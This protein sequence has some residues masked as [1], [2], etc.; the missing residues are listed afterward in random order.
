[1]S[2]AFGPNLNANGPH[3][4]DIVNIGRGLHENRA[5][6]RSCTQSAGA[7]QGAGHRPDRQPSHR[8]R[9]GRDRYRHRRPWHH[10]PGARQGRRG[11]D[12]QH[13]HAFD[14]RHGRAA[15]RRRV[16]RDVPRARPSRA[17]RA[18]LSCHQRD[19]HRAL[20]H[21]RQGAEGAGV[22]AARRRARQGAVLRD[23]RPAV[24]GS[25]PACL[26]GE[27][28]GRAGLRRR[29]DG[30]RRDRARPCPRIPQHDRGAAGRRPPR[31]SGA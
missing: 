20:G 2:Q 5:R 16:E 21:P 7:D 4:T 9:R 12:R 1:M 8:L 27:A 14:P 23:L 31:Q 10:Q 3:A 17:D 13:G 11:A 22:A 25:R 18:R 26:G 6:H 15:H 19:R 29:E 30:G 24:D 28:L